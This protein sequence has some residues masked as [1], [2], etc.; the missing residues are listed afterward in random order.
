MRKGTISGISAEDNLPNLYLVLITFL[1][2]E[3]PQSLT[4]H[5]LRVHKGHIVFTIKEE[6]LIVKHLRVSKLLGQNLR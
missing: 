6:T 5:S 3:D 2:I 1:T 4:E